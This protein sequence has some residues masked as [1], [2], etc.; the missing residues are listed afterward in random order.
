MKTIGI[1]AINILINFGIL[2][3]LIHQLVPIENPLP[4]AL[5]FIAF[6]GFNLATGIMLEKA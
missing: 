2:L 1:L 6:G 4:T 5:L 3:V